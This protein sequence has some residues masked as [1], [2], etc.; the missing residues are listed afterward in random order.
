MDPVRV[1]CSFCSALPVRED[2]PDY[3]ASRKG[4]LSLSAN[5]RSHVQGPACSHS[6]IWTAG[7]KGDS[8]VVGRGLKL[9]RRL[10]RAAQ[11]AHH[12][13]QCVPGLGKLGRV[14][15]AGGAE[16]GR[17]ELVFTQYGWRKHNL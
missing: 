10:R 16:S 4:G 8:T 12:K 3:W 7:K 1:V 2:P 13:V 9:N 14:V 15:D 17:R 11:E 5:R 6:E